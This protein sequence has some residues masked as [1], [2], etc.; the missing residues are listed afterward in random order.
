MQTNSIIT[1]LALDRC[2]ITCR[3]SS[4]IRH[5]PIQLMLQFTI[6]FEFRGKALSRL[7]TRLQEADNVCLRT[8]H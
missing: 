8:K 3:P 2:S 7:R 6:Q 1:V 4:G 5:N